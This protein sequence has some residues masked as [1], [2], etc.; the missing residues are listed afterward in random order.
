MKI[1][2]IDIKGPIINDGDQ[3]V[4]DHFGMP[5]TSPSKVSSILD[6]VMKNK[7]KSV[8]VSI[9]SGGGS[10]F[11]ASEIYTELRKFPGTVNV[12]IVGVA[13]SAASVIAMAGTK[14]EMSP[15]A[16]MMIHNASIKAQ[17]DYRTMDEK[18]TF[19]KN[20]N[21]TIINAY[22]QK[23]G[24]SEE[25][26]QAMMDTETWM[27]AEQAKQHGF[28]DNVMFEVEVGVVASIERMDLMNGVLPQAVI[29][30][31]RNELLQTNNPVNVSDNKKNRAVNLTNNTAYD[32]ALLNATNPSNE[33]S[34]EGQEAIAAL[35]AMKALKEK[36]MD[37]KNI[38][39]EEASD[40]FGLVQAFGKFTS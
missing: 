21:L 1:V 36:G 24:K 34:K 18:S 10:V 9:N 7:K 11:A 35:K 22:K 32:T 19:L 8:T 15:T 37:T 20:T 6:N 12:Q 25:E 4:Y 33:K 38:S 5:A 2:K 31:V 17:G 40:V 23:T 28:I 3:R 30:K 16:Q 39:Y 13:A 14:I 27:T 29:N 26:L